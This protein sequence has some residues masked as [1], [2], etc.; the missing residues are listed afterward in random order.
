MFQLKGVGGING[1]YVSKVEVTSTAYDGNSGLFRLIL[2]LMREF[3]KIYR[4]LGFTD[5]VHTVK[6]RVT[7]YAGNVTETLSKDI[8]VDTFTPFVNL[9]ID[10][11]SGFNGWYVS[12]V[13]VEP[14]VNDPVSGVASVQVA[15][16]GE[17]W[18]VVN[19]SIQFGEGLHTYQFKVID[20]A[21]NSILIPAQNLKVDTVAPIIEMTK[22]LSLGEAVDYHLVD[23][24]SGLYIYRAVIEDE[25]EKYKK[26]VW[27]D[28]ISGNLLENQILWDGKFADGKKQVGENTT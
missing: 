10:G 23:Y 25:D 13:T 5:G 1:W 6:F 28:D 4:P 12:P 19:N 16:D 8:K 24:G 21:G 14:I 2:Q 3:G 7:D 27:V 15:V 9:K 11:I 26:V 20:G 18:A 17:G 22:R